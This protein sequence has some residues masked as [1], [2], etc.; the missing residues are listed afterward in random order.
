MVRTGTATYAP[1]RV[2]L[3]GKAFRLTPPPTGWGGSLPRWRLEPF[4]SALDHPPLVGENGRPIT[5]G[6]GEDGPAGF[7]QELDS[8]VRRTAGQFVEFVLGHEAMRRSAGQRDL[9]SSCG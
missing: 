9:N 7:E 1:A 6:F 4:A 5:A 3:A 8:Q 2:V